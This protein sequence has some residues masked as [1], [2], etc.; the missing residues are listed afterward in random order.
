MPSLAIN[1]DHGAKSSTGSLLEIGTLG[2]PTF[3]ISGFNGTYSALG[4]IG[5]IF[6]DLSFVS[7]TPG[8]FSKVTFGG[9][10]INHTTGFKGYFN[11]P[12]TTLAFSGPIGLL[13]FN[14]TL[15]SMGLE[16]ASTGDQVTV[17]F[18]YFMDGGYFGSPSKMD[19]NIS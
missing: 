5:L 10:Y 16:N 1:N 14:A 3:S 13:N 18:N 8:T 17:H 11:A 6:S 2:A 9:R 19:I 12:L 4:T 15:E 7:T